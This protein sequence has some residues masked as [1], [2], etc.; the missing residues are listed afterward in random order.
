MFSQW[1]A[2]EEGEGTGGEMRGWE[3][4]E[5]EKRSGGMKD[6]FQFLPDFFLL[7]TL[8]ATEQPENVIS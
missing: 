2:L 1:K 7:W 8:A 3:G 4:D 5:E 6:L